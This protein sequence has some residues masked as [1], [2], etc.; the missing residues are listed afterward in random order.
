MDVTPISPG[1][2]ALSGVDWLLPA[3]LFALS[4]GLLIGLGLKLKHEFKVP[5]LISVGVLLIGGAVTAAGVTA[6]QKT[7]AKIEAVKTHITDLGFEIKSGT[8]AVNPNTDSA[9]TVSKAGNDY[10]CT[11][12]APGLEEKIFIVCDPGM[13]AGKGTIEDLSAQI[14]GAQKRLASKADGPVEAP[15]SGTETPIQEPTLK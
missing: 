14:N 8:I 5:I 13:G 11:S 1:L 12:Y 6:Q 15:I 4:I 9:F 2:S 7:E 10:Q 3:C